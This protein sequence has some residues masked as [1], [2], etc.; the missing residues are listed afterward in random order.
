MLRN[1]KDDPREPPRCVQSIHISTTPEF[2]TPDDS[3]HEVKNER[4]YQMAVYIQRMI[5]GR[6]IQNQ[7]YSGRDKCR[8]LISEFRSTHQLSDIRKLNAQD[9]L[10]NQLT[11]ERKS[12][13]YQ[14]RR[15][16]AILRAEAQ[17]M[18]MAEQAKGTTMAFALDL[19]ETV[20]NLK[21]L[22]HDPMIVFNC[23]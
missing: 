16:A 19:L 22:A 11:E 21:N 4:E 10:P 3:E 14:Q 12:A 8:E 9:D 1:R 5:R 15:L 6:A 20:Y 13:H 17:I 23:L 18:E 2:L 7:I